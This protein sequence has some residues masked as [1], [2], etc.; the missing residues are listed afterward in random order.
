[1]ISV[2]RLQVRR[3]EVR[4]A[5][6][7]GAVPLERAVRRDRDDG[8]G[9]T[10]PGGTISSV[11]LDAGVTGSSVPG[12]GLACAA[13]GS[14]T[15]LEPGQPSGLARKRLPARSAAAVTARRNEGRG[16]HRFRPALAGARDHDSDVSAT[17]RWFGASATKS[18]FQRAR[19]DRPVSLITSGHADP[20]STP[21]PPFSDD[22][23]RSSR[24]QASSRRLA[25]TALSSA[26][27]ISLLRLAS[28]TSAAPANWA[29]SA[30]K[31]GLGSA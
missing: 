1:M 7:G 11:A 29:I 13:A 5:V 31:A 6:A 12:S 15:W 8:G 16:Q 22:P 3:R 18:W 19:R 23:K 4:I 10:L 9:D 2:A 30:S 17:R 21:Q 28:F 26:S 25:I 27:A 24:S 20:P 14:R